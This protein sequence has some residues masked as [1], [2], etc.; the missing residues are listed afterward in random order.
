VTSTK[1]SPSRIIYLDN[2]R[3]ICIL[4]M[5]FCHSVIYGVKE[6]TFHPA[7]F[8]GNHVLGDWPAAM[9]LT[10][11][12]FVLEFRQ[13]G[14]AKLLRRGLFLIGVGILLAVMNDGWRNFFECDVLVIIGIASILYPLLR[15]RTV[16]GLGILILVVMAVTAILQR[17][18]DYHANWGGVESV[19]SYAGVLIDPGEEYDAGAW[20]LLTSV[21]ACLFNG[22]FPIFPWLSF[23]LLG[24]ILAKREWSERLLGGVG[25]A[26]ILTAAAGVMFIPLSFYPLSITF[27][28]L[29]LGLVLLVFSL[30]GLLGFQ[31]W[32]LA[33]LSRYS[34]TAY[35]LQYVIL[36]VIARGFG[37][38]SEPLLGYALGLGVTLVVLA[39]L[40]LIDRVNGSLSLE[41]ALKKVAG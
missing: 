9:F 21:K 5:I 6:D 11:S 2:L 7:Y 8:F 10:I 37:Q 28:V 41:G 16:W 20:T 17:T 34:L 1:L 22:Y 27:N 35:V 30:R 12:G 38:F 19:E 23:S 25:G 24:I 26:L 40:M 14:N 18:L 15:A 3:A 4:G 29:L 31:A 32:P 39:V 33:L 36:N 13:S